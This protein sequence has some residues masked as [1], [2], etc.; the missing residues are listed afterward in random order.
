MRSYQVGAVCLALLLN[1][2]TTGEIMGQMTEGGSLVVGTKETPPFAIKTDGKWSGVSI[3]LWRDI[4]NALGWRYEF[5][6]LD[7]PELLDGVEK[8][9]LDAAVGALTITASRE[10]VMD[11][12][13]PYYSTGLS[14]AVATDR[15]NYFLKGTAILALVLFLMG[16]VLWL[17]DRLRRAQKPERMAQGVRALLWSLA[18]LLVI[19]SLIAHV[20]TLLT[21]GQPSPVHSFNELQNVRVGTVPGSTSQAYLL[22]KGIEYEEFS[23]LL[24]GLKAVADGRIETMV[25]DTVLVQYYARTRLQNRIRVLPTS[26]DRQEYG[27]ALAQGSRLREP[28][29]R[30]LLTEINKN[31]WHERLDRYLADMRR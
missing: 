28:L 30:A 24:D 7:L 12:T 17:F 26:L 11:F 6:E 3:D 27:F 15:G 18:I 2:G 5:R 22:A 9:S 1:A 8:G 21:V 16:A 23:T 13:H 19:S 10:A 14:I 31:E 29:N 25:Y 20:T 4:M